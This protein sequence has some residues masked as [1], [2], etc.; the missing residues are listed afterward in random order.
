MSYAQMLERERLTTGDISARQGRENIWTRIANPA[1][2]WLGTATIAST[3]RLASQYAALVDMP[4]SMD[5]AIRAS[6][7]YLEAGLPFGFFLATGLLDDS[8]LRNPELTPRL[9][10]LLSRVNAEPASTDPVQQ[11]Y[12]LL[13]LASRPWLRRQLQLSPDDM[14]NRLGAHDLHPVGPQSAPLAAYLTLART[15]LSNETSEVP[16]ERQG[17]EKEQP[18]DEAADTGISVMA[19]QLADIGRSQAASLRLTMRNQYLWRNA[20]A[21][22]NIVD[23]E[24]VAL[25][26]LAMRTGGYWSERLLQRTTSN[27]EDNDALA[28]LP[29]WACREMNGIVSEMSER[30]Q[31]LLRNYSWRGA[32]DEDQRLTSPLFKH[33]RFRPYKP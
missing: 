8:I 10:R 20:A 3:Y 16:D 17:Q 22:V 27:L 4:L 23:L 6:L 32:S 19:H 15:M 5:L 30:V 7:A 2:P 21:P 9:F 29:A 13:A 11:A 12:L 25:Y 18:V 28:E 31:Q 26:G 1:Q 24:Q 14:L 33:R